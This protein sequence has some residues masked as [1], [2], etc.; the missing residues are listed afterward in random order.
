MGCRA[1][2]CGTTDHSVDKR[3]DFHAYA[4]PSSAITDEFGAAASGYSGTSNIYSDAFDY[5][6]GCADHHGDAESKC[7]HRNGSRHA[8]P[9]EHRQAIARCHRV[10]GWGSVS[11]QYLDGYP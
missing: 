4:N 3:S 5:F 9:G 1:S 2:I 8:E 6:N 11:D 10:G 7:A